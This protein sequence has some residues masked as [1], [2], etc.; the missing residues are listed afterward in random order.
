MREL[1]PQEKRAKPVPERNV[2]HANRRTERHLRDKLAAV[3]KDLHR[4][5]DWFIRDWKIRK[6]KP[7]HYGLGLNI[8]GWLKAETRN[9]LKLLLEVVDITQEEFERGMTLA[10]N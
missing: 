7:E 2:T 10:G 5:W 6:A 1:T 4:E 9:E 3:R 8:Y